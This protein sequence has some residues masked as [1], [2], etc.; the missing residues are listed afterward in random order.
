MGFPT[1]DRVRGTDESGTVW[2]ST[3]QELRFA[4]FVASLGV[5]R[6]CTT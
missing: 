5:A 2:F 6:R 4:A 1:L 3:L